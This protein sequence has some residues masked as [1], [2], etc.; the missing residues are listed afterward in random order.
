MLKS[1]CLFIVFLYFFPLSLFSVELTVQE[2]EYLKT[3]EPIKACVDPDWAP[4]ETLNAKGVYE[5]IGADLLNLVAKN[6]DIVIEV[7]PTKDWDESLIAS[8]EAR[9]LIMSFLNQTPARSEWLI[10]SEPHFSDINVFITR[11]E[12]PFISNPTDLVDKTIV[13]PKGTAMEELIR[14][15]YPNLNI[16]TTDTEIEAFQMVSDKKA[17]MTMR[18]L[19][20]A[21]YTIKQKGFF[22]L[23][24]SGQLPKYTNQLRIGVIK[25]HPMLRDILNK[26]VLG[27]TAKERE[28]IVNQHIVIH[29]QTVMDKSM[30]IK[31]S[32]I[33]IVIIC[34]FMY[35]QYELKRYNAKLLFLSQ[36]DLLTNLYNRTKISQLL[37]DEIARSKRSGEP[38]S[39][40]LMDID[41]FKKINDTFGHQMGDLVLIQFAKSAKESLRR[42]DTIGRWGGEEFLVVCPNTNKEEAIKVAERLRICIYET[43]YPTNTKH[44]VSIGIASLCPE[45][46]SHML[47]AKADDALYQAKNKGRNQVYFSEKECFQDGAY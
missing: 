6:L 44:S 18:S 46:T 33:F 3:L 25:E 31:M 22:N 12:H 34:A 40:L 21:A 11:E 30:T 10:F 37:E 4:F 5:G 7:L 17:D 32:I 24:I 47:V 28:A 15:D 43:D 20:V 39:I 35:R 29:A 8:K 26:A 41:L 14:K 45:D 1:K 38:F 42:Y 27:I 19:I 36:T 2:R 23:K 13:F 16:I 9:C